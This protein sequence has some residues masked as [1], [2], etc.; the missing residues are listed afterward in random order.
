MISESRAKIINNPCW[1]YPQIKPRVFEARED[2]NVRIYLSYID[3]MRIE[4]ILPFQIELTRSVSVSLH[5]VLTGLFWHSIAD[6]KLPTN[7]LSIMN[8]KWAQHKK[9]LTLSKSRS[10]TRSPSTYHI[11]RF[12]LLTGYKTCIIFLR[13]LRNMYRVFLNIVCF[14]RF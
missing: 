7:Q 4:N 13:I 2:Y 14:Q 1:K 6:K 8:N 11:N 9:L 5:G 3:L 10:E 12:F